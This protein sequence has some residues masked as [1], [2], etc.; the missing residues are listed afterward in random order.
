MIHD[1]WLCLFWSISSQ[2]KIISTLGC[3]CVGVLSHSVMSDSLCPHG[4]QHTR[5]PY[6]SLSPRVCSNSFP[7]SQW[8][9]LIILSSVTSSSPLS[10]SQYKGLFQW[11]ISL[12]QMTKALELQ[13][14]HKPF[15]WLFRVDRGKSRSSARL[16]S[17]T[18]KSLWMVIVAME[19]KDACPLEKSY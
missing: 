17:W 1:F 9:H 3:K 13:L 11:V 4:L 6:P 10:L 16:F 7:L 8:C 14:Q 5:L 19:L 18:P 12:H 2:E 15:W